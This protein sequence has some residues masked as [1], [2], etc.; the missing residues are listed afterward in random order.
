MA[1]LEKTGNPWLELGL[2]LSELKSHSIFI[3]LKV[4][5]FFFI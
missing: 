3:M 1:L 2:K 4:G 5:G